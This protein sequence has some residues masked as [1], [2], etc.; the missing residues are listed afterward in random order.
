MLKSNLN[1]STHLGVLKDNASFSSLEQYVHNIKIARTTFATISA[2]AAVA[3]AG[4]WA[5]AWW[6]GFSTPFAVTCTL[7]SAFSGGIAAAISIAQ[8]IYDKQLR[9]IDKFVISLFA[10]YKLG[11]IFY[12]TLN[13]ILIGAN[14][15]AYSMSWAFPAILAIVPVV[16]AVLVW[17]N[18][19]S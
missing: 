8:V 16:S 15:S 4:F 1:E 12:A 7:A 3:A 11:H 17:I 9:G 6:F 10:I 19:Y 2:T 13:P 14:V 18:L 5:V